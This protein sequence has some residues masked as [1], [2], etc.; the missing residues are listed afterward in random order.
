MNW[1]MWCKTTLTSRKAMKT[2]NRGNYT[3]KLVQVISLSSK[4]WTWCTTILMKTISWMVLMMKFARRKIQSNRWMT[5]TQ[6]LLC[7]GA[8]VLCK[9]KSKLNRVMCLFIRLV[10]SLRKKVRIHLYLRINQGLKVA[11]SLQVNIHNSK[12]LNHRIEIVLYWRLGLTWE[13]DLA[14]IK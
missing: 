14:H 12:L 2:C 5:G 13:G 4:M 10:F 7:R 11:C 9:L 6:M 3:M 8:R 1:R